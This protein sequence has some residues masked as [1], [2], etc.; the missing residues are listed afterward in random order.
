MMIQSPI[1]KWITDEFDGVIQIKSDFS[2]E[3]H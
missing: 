2:A 3:Y 1:Q